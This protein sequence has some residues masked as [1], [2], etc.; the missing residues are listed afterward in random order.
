MGGVRTIQRSKGVQ[1]TLFQLPRKNS[2]SRG[3]FCAAD[4]SQSLK[5][6][7]AG[8][9]IALQMR[10][11]TSRFAVI[12]LFSWQREGKERG[13]HRNGSSVGTIRAALLPC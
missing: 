11:E 9:E 13:I 12:Q 5:S 4:E 3:T 10:N 6:L 2:L 7:V 8:S 1:K